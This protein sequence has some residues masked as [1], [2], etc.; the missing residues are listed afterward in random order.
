MLIREAGLITLCCVLFINMGLSG[1]I[2]K[3]LHVKVAPLSCP[4]CLTFWF[5]LAYFLINTKEILFSVTASF[6]ASYLA[7]WL[8]LVYDL[9]A[10]LYN[11]LYGTITKN[12]ETPTDSDAVS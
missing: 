5:C 10:L 7:L 8:T 9:L 1:A 3:V 11:K 4:K 6:I 12:S 2:Q